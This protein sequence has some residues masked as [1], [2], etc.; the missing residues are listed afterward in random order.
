MGRKPDVAVVETHDTKS[1]RY[2]HLAQRIGPYDHL[3]AEAHD[4]QYGR[5]IVAAPRFVMQRQAVGAELR[6]PEALI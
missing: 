2:Q 3:H 4:E 1:H 6:H 5:I